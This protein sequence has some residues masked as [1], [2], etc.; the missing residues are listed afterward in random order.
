MATINQLSTL[1]T[2]QTSDKLIVYSSDNGDARKASLSALMAFVES[3]FASPEFT[4]VINAPTSSGFSIQ[5]DSQTTSVWMI[6]NPTGT[7]AAGTLV[8]PP[9]AD[10]FDGQEIIVTCTQVVTAF[11]INGNGS[12][13]IGTPTSMGAGGFFAIRFNALQ[14]SWYCISQNIVSTFGVL[15]LGTSIN[16]SNGNELLKVFAS[17]GA[18]NELTIAN[19]ATGG[20]PSLSATGDDANISINLIPKGT[21][22]LKSNSVDVVTTTGTQTLTNKT[23]TAPTINNAT[24][25]AP[26]L[27]TPASGVLTNCTGSPTLTAPILGTPNSGTLTNCTGLPVSTG[28]TGLAAGVAT[29]LATPSS[30]N[31]IAAVTDETG[32]GALVFANT[33][34][35]VTPALGAST[36]TTHVTTSYQKTTPVTVAGLTAAATAGAGARHAVTD[37]NAT[38]TAGIGAVV[39]GGGANIVPVFSDGT[40]W[41]I[42]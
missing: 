18:V 20:T 1:N 13:L 27:G 25:T 38:F 7:F 17:L 31:L 39:A 12:T 40:N 26:V 21:G 37:A 16:D 10:C 6:I 35:L 23:L 36:G 34:T 11:T 2:L 30:A 22:V 33:P 28:I 4:T 5:M 3:S 32:T 24:M 41:R 14:S 19:A 8:L 9:T 29:F 15:T 42:G